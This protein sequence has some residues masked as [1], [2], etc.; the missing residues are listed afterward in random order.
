MQ[1]IQLALIG[2]AFITFA[3]I[4]FVTTYHNNQSMASTRLIAVDYEVFGRVQG[5][6]F[7]KFTNEKG[8]SLGLR[9]WVK[10]TRYVNNNINISV[11]MK[12]Y[13][14]ICRDGTVT[15]Q[16]E[17]DTASIAQMKS[18]LEKTGSPMSR[19]EKANFSK[20]R[21]IESFSF[22]NFKVVH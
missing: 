18:W 15:G 6:F 11:G 2:L 8:N 10:N 4:F 9:G 13:K 19:I 1:T 22:E 20:E 17:G 16:M 7:R 21:Q 12:H 5:V 3:I 14:D